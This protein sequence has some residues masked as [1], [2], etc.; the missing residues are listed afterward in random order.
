MKGLNPKVELM[1]ALLAPF[2]YP[3]GWVLRRVR[4][5]GIQHL[6]A[7][8]K[9]LLRMGVFP[10][11]RH[12]Y[13][14]QFDFRETRGSFSENRPLSGIDWNIP[15]QLALLES[16]TFSDELRDLPI[17]EP[18]ELRFYLHNDYFEAGDAE[19][20]YQLIRR[21]KP[22]NIYEIGSGY[23]TLMAIEAIK[24]NQQEDAAYNCNHLCIEPHEMAWLEKTG[25]VITRKKVEDIPVSL[26]C[27]LEENDILF[28]D[29]SHMIRP[30]GDVLF[31]YL[32][33]LPSLKQGV[34]VH[35]HDIFSP[36]NYPHSW[37][38][39][40]VK[41]WNEQYLLEAFLTH[42]A[43]WKV[44]GALNFLHHNHHHELKQ[45]AP[46]LVPEMEP[47]SFYIQRIA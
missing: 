40:D 34:I 28:I 36:R 41:F 6:P 8:R 30:Q 38:V 1:D 16:L 37:L 33:I 10:I 14:P 39:D 11:S 9:A 32:Q 2:V 21:K 35:L 47:G 22:R 19:Y 12:Y 20:W 7:C 44:I 5:L 31:E 29:S 24:K 15:G 17:E 43:S 42:N 45:V 4:L 18:A 23:S 25:V 27:D 26:F 46:F 3:A 13:E